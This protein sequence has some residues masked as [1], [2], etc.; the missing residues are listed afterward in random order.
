MLFRSQTTLGTQVL[1]GCLGEK[2]LETR[3]GIKLEVVSDRKK[4]VAVVGTNRREHFGNAWNVV[5]GGTSGAQA[6]IVDVTDVVVNSVNYKDL[7]REE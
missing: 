4:V 3:K 2:L 5:V 6:R 1:V 7:R